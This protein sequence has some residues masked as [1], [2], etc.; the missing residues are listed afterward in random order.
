MQIN[1]YDISIS[2]EVNYVYRLDYLGSTP[3]DTKKEFQNAYDE[4]ALFYNNINSKTHI[5][6]IYLK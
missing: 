6:V 4:I 5:F 2:A 3:W 1:Q